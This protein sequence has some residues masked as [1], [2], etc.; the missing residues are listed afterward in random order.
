MNASSMCH[1]TL[2]QFQSEGYQR[3]KYLCYFRLKFSNNYILLNKYTQF[4]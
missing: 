2:A 3:Q 1:E 4:Y